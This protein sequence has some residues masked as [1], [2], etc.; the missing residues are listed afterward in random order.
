MRVEKYGGFTDDLMEL[1]DF[2]Q[3]SA[4]DAV[5]SLLIDDGMPERENRQA[6]LNP[7]FKCIGVGFAPHPTL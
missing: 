4:S 2:A 5:N 1:I 3:V 6:L 7:D